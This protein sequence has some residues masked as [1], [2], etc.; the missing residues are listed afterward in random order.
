MELSQLLPDTAMDDPNVDDH[1]NVT[2]VMHDE[3]T[4]A[5]SIKIPSTRQ[6]SSLS[7]DISIPCDTD[8]NTS[9]QSVSP[10]KSEELDRNYDVEKQL[11]VEL[12]DAGHKEAQIS[13]VPSNDGHSLDIKT[14]EI[15]QKIKSMYA[16]VLFYSNVSYLL[17][18]VEWNVS[19]LTFSNRVKLW[20]CQRNGR[21]VQVR[22]MTERNTLFLHLDK[23]N[24]YDH[25]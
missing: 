5:A 8:G 22:H 13:V 25:R 14:E 15:V 20:C 7:A 24:G 4:P 23:H 2:V 18:C 19:L 11:E 21:C 9:L 6:L 16:H 1:S 12:Q 10:C 3:G 17:I